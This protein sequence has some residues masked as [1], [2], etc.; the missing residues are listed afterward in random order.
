MV[1]IWITEKNAKGIIFK[2]IKMAVS[3]TKFRNLFNLK[4]LNLEL[5]KLSKRIKP[6]KYWN[7]ISYKSWCLAHSSLHCLD[8]NH[9][10][11]QCNTRVAVLNAQSQISNRGRLLLEPI[12]VWQIEGQRISSSSI[13]RVERERLCI[14]RIWF[15]GETPFIIWWWWWSAM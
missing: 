6:Q 3:S 4:N 13:A 1:S 9:S 12:Q 14:G 7:E 8:N 11:L 10:H 2:N 5:L 15:E